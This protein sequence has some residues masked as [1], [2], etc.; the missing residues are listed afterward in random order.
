MGFLR[1]IAVRTAC[2]KN[3]SLATCSATPC[4][5]SE[6]PRYLAVAVSI[7]ETAAGWANTANEQKQEP[8]Y[9]RG[10]AE[11]YQ[12]GSCTLVAHPAAGGPLSWVGLGCFVERTFGWNEWKQW[13]DNQRCLTVQQAVW[14]FWFRGL[15]LRLCPFLQT[16]MSSG[17]RVSEPS[18]AQGSILG[19]WSAP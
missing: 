2:D 5:L 18:C 16:I 8:G 13:D 10:L 9:H 11:L 4:L 6:P 19:G 17:A 15:A 7:T 12:Y 1:A 3:L 14:Q